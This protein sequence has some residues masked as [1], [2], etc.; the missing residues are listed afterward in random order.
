VPAPVDKRIYGHF[1]EH[2]NHSVE[3]GLFAEQCQGWGF[4]GEDFKTFWE[5]YGERGKVELVEAVFQSSK[6]CVRLQ[7]N[8]G[9][10]GI[11]QRRIFVEAGQRYD[12]PVWI[13]RS[14]GSPRLT[15]SI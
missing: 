3:D 5:P 4:E 11:R 2:I 1:L 13:K 12:G 9:R 7:S 14:E 6:T 10:A 8:G 15:L